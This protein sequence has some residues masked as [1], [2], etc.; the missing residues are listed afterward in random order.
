MSGINSDLS[1]SGRRGVEIATDELNEAGG[2]GGRKIELVVKD[3]MFDST[4]A[5]NV[6]KEF[7][8]ENIPVVIGHSFLVKRLSDISRLGLI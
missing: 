3:D 2:L 7:I 1:V 6:D 5:L 4:T 8:R